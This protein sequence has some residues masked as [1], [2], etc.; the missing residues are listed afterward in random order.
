MKVGAAAIEKERVDVYRGCCCC[1]CCSRIGNGD[2]KGEE[3]ER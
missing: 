3:D 1:C 2:R